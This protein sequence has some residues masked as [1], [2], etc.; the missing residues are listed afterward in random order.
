ME[1]IVQRRFLLAVTL[2]VTVAEGPGLAWARTSV[3]DPQHSATVGVHAVP[4]RSRDATARAVVQQPTPGGRRD[5]QTPDRRDV[6]M[7]SA[8]RTASTGAPGNRRRKGPKRRWIAARKCLR[9]PIM[10][11]RVGLEPQA[12]VLGDCQDR[13]LPTARE[14][15]SILARPWGASK[16]VAHPA[17]SRTLARTRQPIVRGSHAAA[18]EVAPSIRLLDNGLLTR[19]ESIAQRFPGRSI[20]IVSGYRPSSRGSLHQQARALDLRVSGITNEELVAF[21]K[22]LRDTGCGYYPNSSFV[23]VDVRSA[24][25][26]SASWIDASGPG[27][28]PHYVTQ[29]P[30]PARASDVAVLPPDMPPHNAAGLDA[31]DEH[32]PSSAA[33]VDGDRPSRRGSI[34]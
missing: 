28:A 27:D 24:G 14:A 3:E 6:R 26:G 16:P 23:H 7:I 8:P 11:D 2:C 21:C 5:R 1:F 33:S 34:R 4:R 9:A 13:P 32:S 30:L 18:G 25:A 22:T 15:L 19:L 20:S 29:W 12:L 17:T 31:A 10:F